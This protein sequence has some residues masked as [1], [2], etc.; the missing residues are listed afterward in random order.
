MNNPFVSLCVNHLNQ[1]INENFVKT[2]ETII[3]FNKKESNINLINENFNYNICIKDNIGF[4][5]SQLNQFKNIKLIEKSKNNILNVELNINMFDF[6][7]LKLIENLRRLYSANN[8]KGKLLE[9]I[10]KNKNLTSLINQQNSIYNSLNLLK[11]NIFLQDEELL[12]SNSFFGK[13]KICKRS[14]VFLFLNF[15]E[16]ITKDNQITHYQ[17]F[18]NFFSIKNINW[19]F[20]LPELFKISFKEKSNILSEIIKCLNFDILNNYNKKTE[21]I[22]KVSSF[23]SEVFVNFAEKNQSLNKDTKKLLFIK[24]ITHSYIEDLIEDKHIPIIKNYLSDLD[25]ENISNI[26]IYKLCSNN[27]IKESNINKLLIQLIIK[28]DNLFLF[29]NLLKKDTLNNIELEILTKYEKNENFIYKFLMTNK[30][31]YYI[32]TY[33]QSIFN[34]LGDK[35]STNLISNILSIDKNFISFIEPIV[36]NKKLDIELTNKESMNKKNKIIKI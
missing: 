1:D 35:I 16:F 21:E 15:H 19:D 4:N 31:S 22:I 33:L 9:P 11:D 24:A 3:F 2:L 25:N 18:N 30:N 36:L 17:I 10:Y 32:N 29:S 26:C 13:S 7:V 28:L 14:E 20:L 23:T 34:L 12:Y 5:L 27:N 6:L 8:T